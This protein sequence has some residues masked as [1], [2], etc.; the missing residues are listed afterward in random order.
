MRAGQSSETPFTI[1]SSAMDSLGPVSCKPQDRF[2]KND[3]EIQGLREEKHQ[4][5]KA[6]LRNTSSVSSKTAYSNI[7][8]T[9]QTRLRGMHH[10]WL[11]KKAGEMQSFADS[12]DMKKFFDALKTIYGPQSSETTPLLSADGT[13][14]LTDKEAILEIWAEHF[15]G[16]LN[17]PSMMKLSTDY[18]NWNVIHCLMSSQPFLKQ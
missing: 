2:D 8:R 4:K 7:C 1:H 12:N 15:D 13:S 11:S 17:W 3:K 9:V 18:H 16:A 6:Y 5:H 14:L 10:F